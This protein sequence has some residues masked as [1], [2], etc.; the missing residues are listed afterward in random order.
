KPDRNDGR[1]YVAR[2]EEVLI[3][4]CAD[5]G[6][7]GERVAGRVGIWTPSGK[8]A[9]IGVHISRWI[10]SHGFALNVSTDL[11]DFGAI[12]PCGIS[13]AGVTSLQVLLGGAAPSFAQ[14]EERAAEN[15]AAVW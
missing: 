2:V 3:R 6:V 14:V 15:A 12:V 10:T 9:A 5:F 4:T 13:D 11:R 1:K 8:V 7:R